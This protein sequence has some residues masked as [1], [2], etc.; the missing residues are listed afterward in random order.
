MLEKSPGLSCR[1][2]LFGIDVRENNGLFSACELRD[3]LAPGIDAEASA[4]EG[5]PLLLA[6]TVHP[7]DEDVVRKSIGRNCSFPQA[8]GV[9]RGSRG[10]EHDLGAFERQNA[11]ALGK[12]IVP[13]DLN[14]D[15]PL[16][17]F[18]YGDAGIAGRKIEA[19]P[20]EV[21][22]GKMYLAIN[23]EHFPTVDDGS[24]VIVLFAYGFEE[25]NDENGPCFFRELLET[26]ECFTGC[27]DSQGEIG[28]LFFLRK[29]RCEEQLWIADDLGVLFSRYLSLLNGALDVPF[30]IR[31]SAYLYAGDSHSVD[32]AFKL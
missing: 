27:V 28:I 20:V 13:A 14:A 32:L 22:I 29:P 7:E 1:I 15:P 6:H 3:H 21:Q 2:A 19:F 16:R 18:E 25:R 9:E 8:M 23:A 31:T 12:Q 30:H 24:A 11:R 10:R 17:R 26:T 5:D 4:I